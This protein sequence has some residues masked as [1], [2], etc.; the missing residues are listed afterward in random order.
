[1]A[2]PSPLAALVAAGVLASTLA[3]VSAQRVGAPA[4]GSADAAVATAATE[5]RTSTPVL[6]ARRAPEV[7]VAP[8]VNVDA[9]QLLVRLDAVD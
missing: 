4:E 7:L 5:Q 9:H 8:G 2:R 1:M 3:V 6:S